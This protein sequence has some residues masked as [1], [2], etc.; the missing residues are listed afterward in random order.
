[1]HG[2]NI[3]IKNKYCKMNSTSSS[4]QINYRTSTKVSSGGRRPYL[5]IYSTNINRKNIININFV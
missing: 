1:M 5:R 4:Y 3:F 2:I